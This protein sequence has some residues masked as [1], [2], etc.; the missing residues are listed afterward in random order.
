MEELL[1]RPWTIQDEQTV[2][3][4][5]AYSSSFHWVKVGSTVLLPIPREEPCTPVK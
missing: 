5:K 3:M 2:N 4:L 1:Y